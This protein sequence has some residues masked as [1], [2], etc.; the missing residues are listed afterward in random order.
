MVVEVVPYAQEW[1]SSTGPI[2]KRIV[3]DFNPASLLLIYCVRAY[4]WH[5]VREWDLV[6]DLSCMEYELAAQT[7]E[8]FVR[9]AKGNKDDKQ[10]YG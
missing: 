7:F 3:L 4:T 10:N 9:L 8:L 5:P 2:P 1:V 6:A